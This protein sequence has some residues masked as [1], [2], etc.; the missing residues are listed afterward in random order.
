MNPDF[1]DILS[2]FCAE[3]AEFLLIGAYA[4]AV[5]GLPRATGDLD[6]WVN[7]VGDNPARVRRGLER[8][9]APIEQLEADD[10]ST[11]DLVFQ[12][13]LPPRRIDILTSIDGLEFAGAW[14]RRIE[15]E[16]GGLR[17]PV[18]SR[19]DLIRNKEATGRPQDIA[20]IE[21]LRRDEHSP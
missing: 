17:V 5:H 8:F 13:G 14:S 15:S 20:D 19:D 2:A 18:I 12:I 3:R 16:V 21:W 4:L 1:H 9:G 7:T 6:I 11:P 10:L